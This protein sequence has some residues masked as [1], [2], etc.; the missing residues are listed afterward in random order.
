MNL[1]QKTILVGF[2]LSL[3]TPSLHAQASSDLL[4]QSDRMRDLTSQERHEFTQ[5]GL[6]ELYEGELEDLGP[7]LLLLRQM[8][9]QPWVLL[10]DLQL[11]STSNASL[12]APEKTRSHVFAWTTQVAYL[13]TKREFRGWEVQ[14]T[15][16]MRYQLFRYGM[17][18]HDDKALRPGTTAVD[19]LDFESRAAF[20]DLT[21]TK[22]MLRASFGLSYTSL[23]AA[24]GTEGNF[25]YEWLPNWS[26]GRAFQVNETDFL[27]AMYDGAYHI[28]T[29]PGNR[30]FN[31][32]DDN[33]DKVDNALNL[34]YTRQLNDSFSLQPSL[35]FQRSDYTAS[36]RSRRDYI[37]T[38]SLSANYTLNKYFDCRV[39]GSYERRESTEAATPDYRNLN[40]GLGLSGVYKF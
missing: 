32:R 6:P 40:L 36:G 33:A 9:R 37:S 3:L 30:A 28:S 5:Q 39:F 31:I 19:A 11:Y 23:V 35:R 27:F 15:L 2:I 24:H 14:P 21:L 34:I 7:Q 18:K 4:Q 38:V 26:F 16:G 13:F 8:K 12:N 10:T 29:T 17:L 25:Y 20:A 1:F 22:E